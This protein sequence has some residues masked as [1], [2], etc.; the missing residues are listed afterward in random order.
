MAQHGI[1]CI[2]CHARYSDEKGR[3]GEDGEAFDGM[4][5]PPQLMHNGSASDDGVVLMAPT[6]LNND[7]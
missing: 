1:P 2:L 7:L 5:A 6:P 3:R 4:G